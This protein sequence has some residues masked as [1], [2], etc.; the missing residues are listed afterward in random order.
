MFWKIE[1]FLKV[2]RLIGFLIDFQLVMKDV[3]AISMDFLSN[4]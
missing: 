2:K 3:K 4:F 1:N